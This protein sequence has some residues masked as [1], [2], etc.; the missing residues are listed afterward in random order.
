[1]DYCLQRG[2]EKAA[3]EQEELKIRVVRSGRRTV[4]LQ[5]DEK[6]DITSARHTGCLIRKSAG[7]WKKNLPVTKHIKQIKE[8]QRNEELQPEERLTTEEIR[9][10]AG[11]ALKYIP[12][13]TAYYAPLVKVSY[14]RITIRNQKSRW[15]S[16]SSKGNLN[17][18]CLLMLMPPEVI[19]YVVVHE[20]CHRL[21]MNH[22]ERFWKE[23]ERVLPDYKLRKKWLRENG[24][25]IMRRMA[26]P[27]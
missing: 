2:Y 5:I 24:D 12:Q 4:C 22:S 13:R 15:G 8:R 9:K 19:D 26:L 20:L 18:N 6:L 1:M 14:G 21:E 17:F 25:R 27:G 23:V 10:L 3:A 16:C 7:L 11:E